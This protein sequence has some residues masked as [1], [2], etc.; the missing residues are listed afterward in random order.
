MRNADSFVGKIGEANHPKK[1]SKSESLQPN[2][3]LF[4]KQ[5]AISWD[6]L[7]ADCY[8]FSLGAIIAL[9]M[10]EDCHKLNVRYLF[11][12]LPANQPFCHS[13]RSEKSLFG[14]CMRKGS[15]FPACTLYWQTLGKRLSQPV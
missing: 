2:C 10:G 14:F 11:Y 5:F 7:Y 12:R 6:L 8:T 4:Y 15:E 9:S 13:E 1:E 3:A